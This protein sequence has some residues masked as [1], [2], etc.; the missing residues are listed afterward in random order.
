MAGTIGDVAVRKVDDGTSQKQQ[1]SG[2]R[3][4][5]NYS[6]EQEELIVRFYGIFK[7]VDFMREYGAI[8]PKGMLVKNIYTKV[9]TM[10]SSG[11]WEKVLKRLEAEKGVQVI[12]K[13]KEVAIFK[14]MCEDCVHVNVC[15]MRSMLEWEHDKR[16]TFGTIKC[17]EYRK[18]D[19]K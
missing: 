2:K 17:E 1:K 9:A 7:P 3:K 8:M 11:Q 5:L 16:V 10:K 14:S 15:K 18:D 12:E 13:T 4:R 6:P 19:Q